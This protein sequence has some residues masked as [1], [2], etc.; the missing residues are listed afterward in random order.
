M[1]NIIKSKECTLKKYFFV[2]LLIAQA[3]GNFC[4]AETIDITRQLVNRELL[5]TKFKGPAKVFSDIADKSALKIWIASAMRSESSKYFLNQTYKTYMDNIKSREFID[6]LAYY[7][8]VNDTYNFANTLEFYYHSLSAKLDEFYS[9]PI[10][11]DIS[12]QRSSL[13]KIKEAISKLQDFGYPYVSQM[14]QCVNNEIKSNPTIFESGLIEARKTYND[15]ERLSENLISIK[16]KCLNNN[17]LNSLV[18]LVGELLSQNGKKYS[19]QDYFGPQFVVSYSNFFSGNKVELFPLNRYDAEIIDYLA[20]LQKSIDQYRGKDFSFYKEKLFEL[21]KDPD[22]KKRAITD[23]FTVEDGFPNDYTIDAQNFHKVYSSK[24]PNNNLKNLFSEVFESI[25][26]AKNSVFIDMFF[27]GGTT[28]VFLAKELIK[29][30]QE[31]KDFKVYLVT[32]RENDLGLKAELQ[33]AFNYLRAYA[34]VFPEDGLII[35]PASIKLKRTSLPDFA[36]LLIDDKTLSIIAEK[37]AVKKYIDRLGIY[38]K[39]KSDHSKIVVID[40][41]SDDGVAFVGSKNFTDGSGAIAYDEILKVQGPIV[42]G[43][44]DSYYYDIFE[45]FKGDATYVKLLCSTQKCDK[46]L[47]GQTL[48]HGIDG[49]IS[50]LMIPIDVMNRFK[51]TAFSSTN[52]E[53]QF[54][55]TEELMKD[56]ITSIKQGDTV[57]LIGENNVYGTI[58]SV[59]EDNIHS[60]LSAKKQIIISDQFLYEPKIISAL[61]I[62]VKNAVD[63]KE[64]NFKI[65]IILNSL[66]D[67][68]NNN[69]DFAHI[70][71]NL[72]LNEF[73]TDQMYMNGLDGKSRIQVKW[74]V[75]PE[76]DRVALERTAIVNGSSKKVR[77]SP[78]YHLKSISVDGVLEKDQAFC[79]SFVTDP[80]VLLERVS[81]LSMLITGSANKDNMTMLGGFREFQLKVFDKTSSIKHDCLFWERWNSAQQTALAMPYDFTIP[82]KIA[83]KTSQKEFIQILKTIFLSVYN[84]QEAYFSG[85][86]FR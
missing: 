34:E 38:L 19:N 8:F 44:L 39:A 75:V 85:P 56:R 36:D 41:K 46:T 53:D 62:A 84:Y 76:T 17:N 64:Y 32:D 15:A 59:L 69:T 16:E 71:N 45:A 4:F 26:N 5:Y 28:G 1:I 23:F 6:L 55:L 42:K 54:F 14:R 83:E 21:K 37:N 20:S 65:F 82:E 24:L 35:L 86:L 74:K 3:V 52:N 78:E 27:F 18:T 43:I 49:Q 10:Y 72:F 25:R 63:R 66:G 51:R 30:V 80:K 2:I 79:K 60:I 50:Y 68:I 22:G 7:Y 13:S 67:Y 11:K 31:I 77:F 29:K 33:I 70:P 12:K 9:D 47:T 40:G 61:R 73:S 57:T 81:N 48:G 58:R